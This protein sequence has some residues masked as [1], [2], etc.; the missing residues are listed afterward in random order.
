MT[1]RL[2]YHDAYLREFDAHVLACQPAGEHFEV[3]LDRTA[4]YATSGGQ[5][6]DLGSL[7]GAS[8]LD[9]FERDAGAIIHL[10]DKALAPGHVHGAIDWPRRFDHMQQH[11]GQHLLSAV[12]VEQFQR[13]TVSFHLGHEIST[14]DLDAKSLDLAQVE[15]TE[16]RVNALIFDD[17]PVTIRFG[18][19]EELAA[20]GVR[21]EVEREGILRAI[22][23]EGVECQPCGGTHVARTGQIGLLLLRKFE[24]Q[25]GNWRIEFLCGGRA[26][27]AA[28][29]DF[30]TLNEAARLLGAA[31]GDL[32]AQLLRGVD[33]KRS[34][35]RAR[36]RLLEKLAKYEAAELLAAADAAAPIETAR[37]VLRVFD[38]ADAAY[39]R[40][41]ATAIAASGPAIAL[42]ATRVGGHVV[43]AQSPGLP[44]DLNALLRAALAEHGGRGGGTRDFAQ[45]GLPGAA[46]LDSFLAAAASRLSA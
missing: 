6:H 38:D 18:T 7:G 46:A 24:K 41:L 43:F 3:Q 9:V 34:V 39:L 15:D 45:G 35:D 5:P 21:K 32:P 16:R 8:V 27:A 12:F 37:L 26:L 44:G 28:R 22:E 19:R 20:S 1:D 2:Y 30:A 25:R 11:T 31:P 23:I 13:P 36:Q 29:R 10:V 40:L 17:R 42:L 33:E 4:F 14:I